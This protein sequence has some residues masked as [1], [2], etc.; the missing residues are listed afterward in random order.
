MDCGLNDCMLA[1]TPVEGLT[2][3]WLYD[4]AAQ[5]ETVGIELDSCQI[6]IGKMWAA[7]KVRP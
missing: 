5:A 6:Y 4:Y 7:A 1:N 3:D 2:S